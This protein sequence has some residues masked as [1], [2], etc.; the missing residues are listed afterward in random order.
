VIATKEGGGA[1]GGDKI[2]GAVDG[3]DVVI[4]TGVAVDEAC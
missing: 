4:E 2:S 3:L 1:I